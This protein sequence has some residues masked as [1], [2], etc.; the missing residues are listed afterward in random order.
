MRFV[1]LD[2]TLVSHGYWI[3]IEGLDLTQFRKNPVMY[4]MHQR[5]SKYGDKEV[6]PIGIWD[7]L[8][9][10]EINGIK[11]LTGNPIFDED[12]AFALKIKKKVEKNHIRMA[13]VGIMPIEWSEDEANL[14]LGQTSP[15][16]LK[17]E[18]LEVSIVDIG[19]NKNAIKLY[20]TESLEL[21]LTDFPKLKP[22]FNMKKT[23]ITLGLS[24]NA[25]ETE[26]LAELDKRTA[27]E[28][29]V[30]EENARLKKEVEELSNKVRAEREAKIEDLLKRK[31]LSE[32]QKK[33]YRELSKLNYETALHLITLS[34][35]VQSLKDIPEMP[36]QK[37]SKTFQ[38]LQKEDPKKLEELKTKNPE[39]FKELYK[40]SFGVEP[41]I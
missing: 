36:E 39:A 11:S 3:N 30:T 22:L 6:L 26:I 21:S 24:E 18:L 28:K 8:R 33:A 29:E 38:E 5:P 41:K 2:E 27:K 35:D 23:A 17:S 16:I 15:T 34:A 40:Q 9:I 31:K 25:T 12:D 13:S 10:E 1:L 7:D 37:N 4:W 32:E 19:A 20:N 14:K